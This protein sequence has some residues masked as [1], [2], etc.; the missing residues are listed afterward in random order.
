MILPVIVLGA[1]GHA[2]VLLDILLKNSVTILGITDPNKNI[3]GKQI[4]GVQVLGDDEVVLK[5]PFDTVQLVNGLGS[6]GPTNRRQELYDK[7]KKMGYSFARVVHPS[8]IIALD[9]I[10]SEGV[11]VMA[12]AIIQPGSYIGQN[13]IINTKASVDHD[14]LIGAHVHLAPGVTVSGGVQV[15]EKVHIGSG[16]TVI[17]GIFIEKN[18][19]VGAGAMVLTDIP[20]GVTV[21]GMPARKIL[22]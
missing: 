4:Q 19:V 10:I 11:Q 12:G 1:G 13:T 17:Q 8:A 5:Y 22:R 9:V 18:S 7:F 2:K 3:I 20:E 16:A 14:C 21:I 6:V 15:G